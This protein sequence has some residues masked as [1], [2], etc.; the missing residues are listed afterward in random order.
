MRFAAKK[1]HSNFAKV[2][3]STFL[4]KAKALL[5]K[6]YGYDEFRT[7]QEEII[8]AI[9]SGRDTLV[10][11]PTGGGKSICYQLPAIVAD[12]CCVVI[13][14]L[15]SLMKDQV[16]ALEANGIP[17]AAVHSGND[18]ITNRTAMEEA[19]KG[20]IKLL[21]MSPERLVTEM[22]HN[23]FSRWVS[24]FAVDEAHCIS[25]WGHD[26]RPEYAELGS[27]K[28][29]YPDLPVIALTA[30]ADK[31]TRNDIAEKLSLKNPFIYI[32]SFDRP[33]ISISV[34][35]NPGKKDKMR[36]IERMIDKYPDDSGII[37]CLSRKNAES[38]NAELRLRGYDSTVYHA[39]LSA[40]ERDN[41]Q[42]SFIS[43]DTKI[44]CATVAFG[45]GIDKSNVRW[46]IH[47]NMP[48]NIESYYQEIGRAGRDGSPAEALMF[49]SFAD[50]AAIRKFIE[51]SGKP[52]I[53]NTKLIRMK[54][55]CE[56]S[57]CRRRI[58]LN[59]FNETLNH[60][61]KNCDVC[62]N[63][64]E[65]ID[66]TQIAQ[67][68]LSAMI[69]INEKAGVTLL[70]DILR[71]STR[72]EIFENGFDK[73]KT[74]GVGRN[75][76]F[77]EWNF[78]MVQ[79]L[80][81]GIVDIDYA[82]SNH[83]KVTQYGKTVLRGETQEKLAKYNREAATKVIEPEKKSRSVKKS[84]PA[85][86]LFSV[87]K[88]LRAEIAREEKIAPYLVFSDKTLLEMVKHRPTTL[89][90]FNSING[91]GEKKSIKYWFR[92]TSLIKKFI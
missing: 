56:S 2:K 54:E 44:V 14:P 83:L 11:M 34:M 42:N 40:V 1:T 29:L 89:M 80:Q 64:P 39:G 91:V 5:R 73:I 55:F 68:A 12:R 82:D 3:D 58:L 20:H 21:Y 23:D 9:A 84:N 86:Q 85:E 8:S 67:M 70:I 45:M 46:V 16:T 79:L 31:L 61:C 41:A 19:F 71:G 77:A 24:F 27:I 32:S 33:N 36:I 17:A 75:L 52:G 7:G 6:F 69:R 63:P 15:I 48:K 18:D 26:F 25:Q 88:N 47:N 51:E 10:L 4:S 81:L 57:V 37:Y 78:Y 62:L 38:M 50:V 30:T 35:P 66:G 43:G 92:F 13:S 74:Y 76:S 53:D 72:A 90:A 65:R 28:K 59:Y 49:Y 60:D 87:L 22:R